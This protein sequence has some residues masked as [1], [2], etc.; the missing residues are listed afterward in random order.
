MRAR[1]RA[2]ILVGA[3]TA[4]GNQARIH[5]LA[6]L[7]VRFG[8]NVQPGQIV[9]IGSEPGKEPLVRAIAQSAYQAGAR[10]VDLSVF[11]IHIKHARM[12]YADPDTLAFVPPWYGQ[13]MRALGELRCAVITLTGPVAPRIMDGIDPALLGQDL[14]P[15]VRESIEIVNQRVSNWT[16][17]PCPTASWAELVHP[18]V[19][20]AE[21]L[22]RLWRDVAHVC[23]VDEPDPVAAWEERM[24]NLVT[25]AGKLDALG[26]DALRF[27][28]PGTDLTV[29]LFPSASWHCARISTVD[30]I[31][32]APNLPT[33]EVFTTPDPERTNGYVRST[34]PLFVSGAMVTGLRVRFEN[35]RAVEIDADQGADTVR[36]LSHRDDGSSRLG[37]VALVDGNSRI[38]SLDTVFFDTL[39]DE[40]AA[41]HIALGEGLDF[42]VGEEDQAR[43]NRSELHMDFMIGSR[44]VAVTG[45]QR[46]GG[47]VP[48]L[49]QGAWQI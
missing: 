43:I 17:A 49:R 41:S 27:E 38:G 45:I 22:E 30:G 39:L 14:L 10:F 20:P 9:S 19:D 3:M 28:G 44:E 21:A 40:N 37:E 11:D 33:E 34:K 13:R 23:R 6:D 8:A 42:T 47:E 16:A 24:D 29:G 31:V 32:H 7:I 2:G 26:L 48:L 4:D 46:G 15:R 35:G 36:A 1:G 25:V 12:L 18:E 5:A